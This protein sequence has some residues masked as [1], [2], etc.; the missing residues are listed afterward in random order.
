MHVAAPTGELAAASL[1]FRYASDAVLRL[2]A[3]LMAIYGRG[4]RSRADRAL[5]VLRTVRRSGSSAEP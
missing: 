1:A 3:G 5:E 4:E 2:I